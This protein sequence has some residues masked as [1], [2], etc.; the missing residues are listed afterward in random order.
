MKVTI[1]KTHLESTSAGLQEDDY[2]D[3]MKFLQLFKKEKKIA[4]SRLEKLDR[5]ATNLINL[6]KS[7]KHSPSDVKKFAKFY[8][9]FSGIR[10][11]V[12]SMDEY[13]EYIQN[14]FGF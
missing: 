6:I 10:N 9:E 7:G 14:I 11:S 2:E 3:V 1:N 4:A 8:L 12:S 5:S 13:V